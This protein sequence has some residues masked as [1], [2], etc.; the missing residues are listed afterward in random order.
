MISKQTRI[1]R[2]D[3]TDYQFDFQAFQTY[4]RSQK[5]NR[6][7]ST[8]RILE[9]VAQST[10]VTVEAVK[11]WYYGNNGPSDIELLRKI[12]VALNVSNYLFLLRRANGSESVTK[13]SAAQTESLKR[14]YDAIID[15]LSEFYNT[16]GFTTALWYEFQR[17][18]SENPEDDIYVYAEEKMN[19]VLLV[20]QKEYFYLHD[21]SVYSEISEYAEND[22]LDIFDGK[23][24]YAYRIEAI[25]DGN[26]TTE[27]DYGK[28]L[29]R[30]HEIIEKYI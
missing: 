17:N 25:P 10:N 5:K 21:T 27:D 7:L 30:L 15:Y 20:V 22:L 28:A 23:V 16:G 29:K 14:I 11:Q 13:L 19:A 18:G 24:G 26:P 6:N 3:E 8:A 2:V 12:A 4:T 9:T 1:F